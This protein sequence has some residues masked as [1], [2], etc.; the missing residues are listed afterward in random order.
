[1]ES[2]FFLCNVAGRD[3]DVCS[4]CGL[5]E[6]VLVEPPAELLEARCSAF[7]ICAKALERHGSLVGGRPTELRSSRNGREPETEQ[8]T[9]DVDRL[10][11]KKEVS[12]KMTVKRRFFQDP[13]EDVFSEAASDSDGSEVESDEAE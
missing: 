5:D 7:A 11:W 12:R 8:N 3:L 13:E 6:A 1:M 9:D 2:Q 10:W 4:I